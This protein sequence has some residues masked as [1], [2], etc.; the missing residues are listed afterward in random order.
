MDLANVKFF[1]NC[2]KRQTWAAIHDH[3]N[4]FSLPHEDQI[5]SQILHWFSYAGHLSA[6]EDHLI[7]RWDRCRLLKVQ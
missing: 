7:S 1:P 3:V 2:F 4:C 5:V 6:K